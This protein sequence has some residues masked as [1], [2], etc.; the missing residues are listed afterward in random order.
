MK[1]VT[2][3]TGVVCRYRAVSEQSLI[4]YFTSFGELR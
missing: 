2:Y 1:R 4:S 3:D